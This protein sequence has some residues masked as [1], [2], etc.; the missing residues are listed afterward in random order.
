MLEDEAMFTVGDVV[1]ALRG[2]HGRRPF[3]NLGDILDDVEKTAGGRTFVKKCEARKPKNKEV[4][5]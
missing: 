5:K 1:S 2:K 4:T 3:R